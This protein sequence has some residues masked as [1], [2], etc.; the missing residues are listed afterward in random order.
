MFTPLFSEAVNPLVVPR[1]SDNPIRRWTR[2]C[3]VLSLEP[4]SLTASSFSSRSAFAV[5]AF[6][7]FWLARVRSAVCSAWHR[8]QCVRA[9]A[10]A[11][12]ALPHWRGLIVQL[13]WQRSLMGAKATLASPRC[14]RARN[15]SMALA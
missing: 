12:L 5:A 1:D 7:T 11:F 3:P 4:P 15:S 2:G 14:C 10:A 6:S 9:L 13:F 8:S